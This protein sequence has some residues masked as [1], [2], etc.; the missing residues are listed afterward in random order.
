M[1]AQVGWDE[2]TNGRAARGLEGLESW[3]EDYMYG[4]SREV[5]RGPRETV[6]QMLTYCLLCKY[7]LWK[8]R[9]KVVIEKDS[10]V[11]ERMLR[12]EAE[13]LMGKN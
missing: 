4:E 2:L 9:C 8:L 12:G 7:E 5:R 11:E 3:W 6:A 13:K 1:Q 10:P